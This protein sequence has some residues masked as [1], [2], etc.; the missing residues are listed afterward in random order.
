[1]QFDKNQ[2][3]QLFKDFVKQKRIKGSQE[4]FKMK[5]FLQ[6]AENSLLIAQFHKDIKPNKDQAPK[7][8]WDYWAITIAYYSMLYAAKA[9]LVSKG[10]EVSDHDAAQI[11]LGHLLVPDALEKEDLELLNQ[12]YKILEDEYVHY[13][14]DAKKESH[15]ARYSA[16]H[17][18]TRRRVEEIFENATQFV[19]KMGLILQEK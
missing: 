3:Q 5:L 2:Y 7:L 13:F 15:I 8:Y 12:A 11:A 10:Y 16:I 6:K 9:A 14:E 4:F 1:M 17:T 19:A 18:Y